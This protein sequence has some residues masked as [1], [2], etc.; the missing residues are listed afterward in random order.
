MSIVHL[1][2]YASERLL[3]PHMCKGAFFLLVKV[4]GLTYR[5]ESMVFV[6]L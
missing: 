4:V 5:Y 6:E 3:V 1:F 2:I